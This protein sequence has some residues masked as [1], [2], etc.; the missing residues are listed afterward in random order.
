MDVFDLR[1]VM[2]DEKSPDIHRQTEPMLF[3]GVSS[4]SMALAWAIFLHVA[5][6]AARA[7]PACDV[8]FRR[9][10]LCFV[11]FQDPRPIFGPGHQQG[12][13]ETARKKV[14]LQTSTPPHEP[15]HDHA[16]TFVANVT[17]HIARI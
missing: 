6:S 12:L 14:L 17:Q 9:G 3:N 15:P 11:V 16:L 4:L 13:R 2:L 1:A 8:L 7:S 10:R 5:V